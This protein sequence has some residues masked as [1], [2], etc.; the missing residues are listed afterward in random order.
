MNQHHSNPIISILI[1]FALSASLI[2]NGLLNGSAFSW[3]R[4]TGGI[5]YEL[6]LSDMGVIAG[7]ALALTRIYF[8]VKSKGKGE[9]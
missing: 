4:F 7:I 5:D 2:I 1:E 3:V 9:K 8:M 6:S